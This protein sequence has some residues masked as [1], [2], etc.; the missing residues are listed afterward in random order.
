MTC[1][2]CRRSK[3]VQLREI[4]LFERT[5]S[6]APLYNSII[7][8]V[9][10]D[11]SALGKLSLKH[12][13]LLRISYTN[14]SD[15]FGCMEYFRRFQG[16]FQST[17]GRKLYFT[18]NTTPGSGGFVQYGVKRT[19]N[20]RKLHKSRVTIVFPP[21]IYVSWLHLK[22]ILCF[23]R[24]VWWRSQTNIEKSVISCFHHTRSQDSS[25]T[26]GWAS[27]EIGYSW[28]GTQGLK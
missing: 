10:V 26:F 20:E 18:K 8:D 21:S 6:F 4:E 1:S 19:K 24:R 17:N 7:H 25:R 15:N 28:E 5:A 16:S 3:W 14:N 13:S 9:R 22:K 27:F 2:D 11:N 12:F 23:E